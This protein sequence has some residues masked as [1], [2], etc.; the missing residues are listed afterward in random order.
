MDDVNKF[1]SA[2]LSVKARG[3]YAS[4]RSSHTGIGKTLEDAIGVIENNNDAPDL[5]GFEIKSHRAFSE[6]YV[7]LFTKAPTF[8]KAVNNKLRLNY[9]SIDSHFPDIK[10]LHTSIFETRW[11]THIAGYSYKLV[12]DDNEKKIFLF[13]KN[14]ATDEIVENG[15]YWT[16]EVL[17]NIFTTKLQNLAFIQ[18]SV[19]KDNN[20]EYFTFK[21]CSL[22]YG[23]TLESFLTHLSNGDIMFDIRVGAYKNP[24]SKSYGKMHDHGS[25]F[26]IKKEKLSSLYANYSV[27]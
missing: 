7:T 3:E 1:T 17:S 23:L 24:L 19:R 16:Y 11:N 4:N 12:R 5:H 13:I 18:A 14:I 22:F 8:P 27:L 26:R 6:S 9:G 25:G 2:F 21:E 20:K 15:I 10:V